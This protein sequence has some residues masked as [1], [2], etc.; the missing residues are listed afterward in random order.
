[1]GDAV[2]RILTNQL[3][4]TATIVLFLRHFGKNKVLSFGDAMKNT[5]TAFSADVQ[6]ALKDTLPFL[7]TSRD[8]HDIDFC[9]DRGSS[10]YYSPEVKDWRDFDEFVLAP[11]GDQRRIKE[12][13][14]NSE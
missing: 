10:R 2:F 1:M 13:L 8:G 14:G 12:F 5:A 3:V 7:K 9:K 6:Q 4:S 11:D